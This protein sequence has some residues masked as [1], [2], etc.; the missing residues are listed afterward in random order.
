MREEVNLGRRL[1]IEES[2]GEPGGSG[3]EGELSGVVKGCEEG[4]QRDRRRSEEVFGE[5][6][7]KRVERARE[8]R[9]GWARETK[10]RKK[11]EKVRAEGVEE[12]LAGKIREST[13]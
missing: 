9:L 6:L 13:Q 7:I 2:L 5:A 3:W 4:F 1:G 8:R 12:D 11:R 10:E